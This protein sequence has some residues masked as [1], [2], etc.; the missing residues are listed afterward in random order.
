[1]N[2]LPIAIWR[3]R[4]PASGERNSH[5]VPTLTSRILLFSNRRRTRFRVR[6]YGGFYAV[7]VPGPQLHAFKTSRLERGDDRLKRRLLVKA[8][9]DRA[10]MK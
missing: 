4:S 7:A 6:A 5:V 10:Q 2:C 1:M 8:E 9:C 3:H